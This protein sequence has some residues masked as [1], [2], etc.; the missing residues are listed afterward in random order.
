M[1]LDDGIIGIASVPSGAS[2]GENEARE[3]RDGDPS[4]FGGK[5][6]RQAARHVTDTISSALRGRDPSQQ[7]D[8]DRILIDLDG[9]ENKSRLGANAIL[10][11]SMAVARATAAAS[12][13]PL[14]AYLSGAA[15]RRMPGP[16]MNVING[17]AHADNSLEFQEFMIVPHGA[18]SFSEALRYGSETFHALD[19]VP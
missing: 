19:R 15:A 7:W 16:M 3:L 14:Y 5:G 9:T 11:A 1:I 18:S 8:I 17:G 2:T 4:R 6:V 13:R 10:G 12:G